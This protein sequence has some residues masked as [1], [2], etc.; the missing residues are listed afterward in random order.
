MTSVMSNE[1]DNAPMLFVRKRVMPELLPVMIRKLNII[2]IYS[3]VKGDLLPVGKGST[4]ETCAGAEPG[5]P[6]GV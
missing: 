3:N 4:P 6:E 2:L 5:V 1:V